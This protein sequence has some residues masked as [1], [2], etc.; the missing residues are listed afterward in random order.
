[1]TGCLVDFHFIYLERQADLGHYGNSGRYSLTF[2][3]S[4]CGL[5]GDSETLGKN[6]LFIAVLWLSLLWFS[7]PIITQCGIEMLIST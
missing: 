3:D 5:L 4:N 2:Y 6:T 1:M 7:S